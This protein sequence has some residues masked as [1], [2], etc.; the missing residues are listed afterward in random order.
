ML[1]ELLLFSLVVFFTSSRVIMYYRFD[2][3]FVLE[4]TF[5][6]PKRVSQRAYYNID[7]KVYI[8]KRVFVLWDFQSFFLSL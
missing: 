1:A 5:V 4:E 2:L 7:N 8:I 3:P 6:Q